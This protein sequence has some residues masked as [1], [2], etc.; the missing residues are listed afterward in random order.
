MS[1]WKYLFKEKLKPLRGKLLGRA[2]LGDLADLDSI[3]RYVSRPLLTAC[4]KA[5]SLFYLK[6]VY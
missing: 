2:D 3:D 5:E 4:I 6:E 1:L